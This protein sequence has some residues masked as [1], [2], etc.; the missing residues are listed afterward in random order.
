MSAGAHAERG[1]GL[2]VERLPIDGLV[3]LH[4]TVHADAR[5]FFLE[6]WSAA[7]LHG[8][9][10]D[11]TFV[12]DNHSRS[13]EGTL[14]GLHYQRFDGGR[15]GQAK[16]VRCGRGRIFDVAVDLRPESPTFGRWHAVELDDLAHAELFIPAGCA[17][18]FAVLS[19]VADVLY[20]VS[21][22]YDPAL[23][24]GIAWDDSTLAIAWPLAA[25]LLSERDRMNPSFE[26]AVS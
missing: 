25:P 15:P 23:E 18:G 14:R 8:A 10:I 3:L 16:L 22:P 2:R 1:S 20:K 26:D 13:V 17:H 19:P 24:R 4:P 5:G 9:G 11:A 12:Q 7:G 6:T 21:T